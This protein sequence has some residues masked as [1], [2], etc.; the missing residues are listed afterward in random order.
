MK[1]VV[2]NKATLLYDFLAGRTSSTQLFCHMCLN[3]KK[4]NKTP[5]KKPNDFYF[6]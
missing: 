6:E 2:Q 1:D 5:N 3:S 4:Q